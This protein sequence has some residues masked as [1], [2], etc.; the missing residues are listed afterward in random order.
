MG[1]LSLVHTR[2]CGKVAYG[3]SACD[4][5]HTG[6]CYKITPC[7]FVACGFVASACVDSCAALSHAACSFAA[8]ACVDDR[9]TKSHAAA[10][11]LSHGAALQQVPVWARLYNL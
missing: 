4:A 1:P 8:S 3:K 7:G 9:A 5:V 2:A 11:A 6:A 10:A